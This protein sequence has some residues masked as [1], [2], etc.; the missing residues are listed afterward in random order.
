[1]FPGWNPLWRFL[2]QSPEE[3]VSCMKPGEQNQEGVSIPASA[4]HHP[5]LPVVSPGDLISLSFTSTLL[6]FHLLMTASFHSD[7]TP[8]LRLGRKDVNWPAALLHSKPIHG[9]FEDRS[10]R[11]FSPNIGVYGEPEVTITRRPEVLSARE[12]VSL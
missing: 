9:D 2:L 12:S 3:R 4:S 5:P 10:G 11:V 8:R 1:M 6:S 7:S